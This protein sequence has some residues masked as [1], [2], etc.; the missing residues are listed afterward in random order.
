MRISAD[1][2]LIFGLFHRHMAY[3]LE[4]HFETRRERMYFNTLVSHAA[5]YDF[6]E[7]FFASRSSVLS[8][9]IALA[10]HRRIGVDV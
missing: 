5:V 8:F 4:N 10:D 1:T 2:G 6:M 3:M 7:D 9:S